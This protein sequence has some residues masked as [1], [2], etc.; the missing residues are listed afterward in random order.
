LDALIRF[1]NPAE[2]Q[3][4]E[5]KFIGCALLGVE[6]DFDDVQ[7]NIFDDLL[8][9]SNVQPYLWAWIQN[10]L[11]DRHLALTINGHQTGPSPPA[12]GVP[13]GSPLSP[14]LFII[15]TSP[16]HRIPDSKDNILSSYVNDFMLVVLGSSPSDVQSKLQQAVSQHTILATKYQIKFSTKNRDC[17]FFPT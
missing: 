2:S 12:H 11:T 3:K 13:Q 8:K 15:Y 4:A 5:S 9:N 14:L 6:G 16:L 7:S 10:F 17:I 1:F